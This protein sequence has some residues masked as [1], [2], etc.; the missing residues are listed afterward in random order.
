MTTIAEMAR[1]IR[2]RDRLRKSMCV[3]FFRNC[4]VAT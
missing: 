3:V 2:R 4:I 1:A